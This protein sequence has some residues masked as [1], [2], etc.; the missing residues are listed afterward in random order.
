MKLDNVFRGDCFK[1]LKTLPPNSVDLI[2]SS[3]PYNIGK[4]YETK[5]NLDEYLTTQASVTS[6]L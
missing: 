6:R 2:V 1:Y 4:E 3:P 5:V